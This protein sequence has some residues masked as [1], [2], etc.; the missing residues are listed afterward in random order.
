LISSSLGGLEQLVHELEKSIDSAASGTEKDVAAALSWM[1]WIYGVL[2]VLHIPIGDKLEKLFNRSLEKLGGLESRKAIDGKIYYHAARSV[3]FLKE[4]A[5]D[6]SENEMEAANKIAASGIPHPTS[7][8]TIQRRMLEILRREMTISKF[9]WKL[10]V[11]YASADQKLARSV[12]KELQRQGMIVFVDY[13]NIA[14]GSSI[15]PIV[16][17]GLRGSKNALLLI[18]KTYMERKWTDLERIWFS[19]QENWVGQRRIVI[20]LAGVNLKEFQERY[21]TLADRRIIEFPSKETKTVT[22]LAKKIATAVNSAF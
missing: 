12:V 19:S 15:T 21:P 14:H 10:F 13:E 9:R 3:A 17:E 20:V 16:E 22:T 11:S 7:A 5:I 8:V 18:T 1:I 4:G 6:S 2:Y